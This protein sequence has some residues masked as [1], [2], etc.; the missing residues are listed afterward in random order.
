MTNCPTCGN[1]I[2]SGNCGKPNYCP[3]GQNGKSLDADLIRKAL[4][5][6]TSL[7]VAEVWAPPVHEFEKEQRFKVRDAVQKLCMEAEIELNRIHPPL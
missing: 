5:A 1:I 2:G 6:A 7:V 3:I 4:K